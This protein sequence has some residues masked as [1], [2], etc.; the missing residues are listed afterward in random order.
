MTALTEV[1]NA[2]AKI[3]QAAQTISTSNITSEEIRT[4][5][6][7]V[8]GRQRGKS[9]PVKESSQAAIIEKNQLQIAGLESMLK[10]AE[11]RADDEMK[12][13]RSTEML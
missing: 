12:A 10:A 7:E 4:I 8:V 6:E 2:L 11:T 1:Q 9:G 13:R 5:I 3:Q